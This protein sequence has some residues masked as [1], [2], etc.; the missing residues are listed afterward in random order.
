MGRIGRIEFPVVLWVTLAVAAIFAQVF[1][2]DLQNYYIYKGVFWHTVR[3]TNL[4]A[5]YPLEHNDVNHY[6]PFFSVVMAPFAVLPNVLGIICWCML[7]ALV[8]LVAIRRLPISNE[9]KM[10]VLLITSVEM[11]TSIH[12]LQINPMLTAWFIFAFLLTEKGNNFW[13][14]FF[15]AAAFMVKIYGA[16]GLVFIVFS[17]HKSQF[18][19]SFLFWLLMMF[20]LP[21][22]FSSPSFIFR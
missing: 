18:I 16:V 7:N 17:K 8:L 1:N 4:Y 5:T 21:M 9:N 19:I 10:L 15:L 12:S 13:A 11:M 22:T 14:T 3:Q 2:D 6:G 20:A